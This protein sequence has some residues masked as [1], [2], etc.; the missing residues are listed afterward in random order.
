MSAG[1]AIKPLH[2]IGRNNTAEDVIAANLAATFARGYKPLQHLTQY[3][4]PVSIVGAGPSLSWTYQDIVGD[5]IACN[6]AQDFLISRGIIPKY[7][8][9]WDAHP[10]MEGILTPHKDVTYLIASRCHPSVFEK[11]KDFEVLVWHALGGDNVEKLLIEHSRMEPMIAGGSASAMR[12]VYLAGAMGYTKEMHLFGVD[13]S[14]CE[15]DTHVSGSIV[16][17]KKMQL[18]VCGKWFTTAPWMAMQAGDAKVIFPRLRE[19]GVRVI[20]HGT[21]LLPYCATFLGVETPDIKISLY[22]KVRR[23]IHAL[24]L[25][26]LQIRNSQ[27]AG[28]S[29]AGIR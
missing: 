2:M 16:D 15:D 7:A 12:S 19:M 29:N 1:Q 14:Y 27:L 24:A 13:S 3:L 23:E 17:Q 18:R 28:G 5:V 4:G 10:V 6:S 11:L 20:V 21:G 25:L 8:M 22:E 26:F 9:V